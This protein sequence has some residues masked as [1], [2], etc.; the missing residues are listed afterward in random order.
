MVT[1]PRHLCTQSTDAY[2]RSRLYDGLTADMRTDDEYGSDELHGRTRISFIEVPVAPHNL[3]GP[4]VNA[5]T[6]HMSVSITNFAVFEAVSI[7]VSRAQGIG[8]RNAAIRRWCD[9]GAKTPGINIELI[10]ETCLRYPYGPYDVPLFDGS[11]NLSGVA[12]GGF[13]LHETC[14]TGRTRNQ[15]ARYR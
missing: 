4:V 3:V 13:D 12:T 11:M 10:E 2:R 8:S 1:Q 14:A 7:D 15:P 9:P 6:L 5:K